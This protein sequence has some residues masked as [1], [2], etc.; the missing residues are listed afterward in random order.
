MF[1]N[2]NE[3]SRRN[4]I[5]VT[6]IGTATM[7]VGCRI[8]SPPKIS[9]PDEKFENLG[10]FVRIS[11][12]NKITIISPVSEMGQGTHTAH[13]MIIAEELECN[14]QDI[15]VITGSH[16]D[17]YRSSIGAQFT[18]G[19]NGIHV[20]KELLANIGAGSKEL[21]LRSGAEFMNVRQDECI[22]ENGIIKHVHTG[23]TIKYGNLIDIASKLEFPKSPKLKSPNEYQ[24]I[25]KKIKRLDTSSKVNGKIIYGTDIRLPGMRFS[26][27]KQSPVFGGS[28][29]V[30]NQAEV[31]SLKGVEDIIEIPNGVAIVADSTWNAIKGA[32]C[33]KFNYHGGN[34]E[35]INSQIIG[36]KF[37]DTLNKIGKKQLKGENILE[38]EYETPY[39]S[40]AAIEPM[41]CTAF[42]TDQKCEIWAPTQAQTWT[43]EKAK[44]ITGLSE[45]NIIIHTMPIGGGFGRRLEVDFV[46]QALI[47]SKA[48]KKPVQILWSREEDIQH[49]Y[50]H[51][52]SKS[53]FQISLDKDGQPKQLMNQFVKPSHWYRRYKLFSMLD[54]DPFSHYQTAHTHFINKKF[55][56]KFGVKHY[57]D[58]EN[59]DVKYEHV[60]F[61]IPNGFWRTVFLSNNFFLESA[62]DE[63]AFLS[64]SDPLEYRKKLI[65][66]HPRLIHVLDKLNTVSNWSE[67]LPDG[68]GK[69]IALTQMI[70]KGIVASVVQ[71]AIGK[72][73]KLK[74]EKV[75]VVVDFGKIINPD[76]V[77]SQVEGSVV[78]GISV[79]L[80]EEITFHDGRVSQSNYDDYK[81]ARMKVCPEIN[82]T[83]IESDED[84][85][86]IDGSLMPIPPAI[87]NAIFAATGKRIRKLPIGKQKLV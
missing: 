56:T 70:G 2:S 87:T 37:D 77:L 15:K 9:S 3:I 61:G 23:N 84:V 66:N 55:S 27:I 57:Y 49:G 32:E 51:S 6:S 73:N 74:I 26:M 11:K 33:L 58:I 48:I 39:L 29:E 69:G 38:L 62:I 10:L 24:I 41:N 22:A 75:D 83:I 40:H 4:F 60:D 72:R 45:K 71:V 12:D 31:M 52:G 34:S 78:M 18:G 5:R 13:A 19:S 82:V 79:A 44:K 20:W 42:V 7:L 67:K 64:K 46:E 1:A 30:L 86:G 16:N 25:G 21:L 36:K 80:K 81:I 54:F 53:R 68:K 65:S 63:C 35:G 43:L 47:V 8:H 50:Y 76:I 28:L 85:R 59:V 14:L 17:I